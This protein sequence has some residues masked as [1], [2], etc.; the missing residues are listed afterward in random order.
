MSIS[1]GTNSIHLRQLRAFAE[2]LYLQAN[3]HRENQNYVVA[4]ALY[5]R[6]LEVAERIDHLEHDGHDSALATRIRKDRQAVDELLGRRDG[7]PEKSRLEKAQK[8]GR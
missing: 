2:N 8:V 7:S 3:R 1:N 4:H 6:A 5:G